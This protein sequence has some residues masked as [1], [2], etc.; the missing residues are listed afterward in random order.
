[1][2]EERRFQI[3][4]TADHDLAIDEIWPDGDAP[5]NPT[6]DDV[7]RR[8]QECGGAR[9]LWR[10]W[11]FDTDPEVDVCEVAPLSPQQLAAIKAL[12]EARGKR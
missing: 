10:D 2:S 11:G 5:E 8:I 3:T 9:G 7:K 4:I 1:M 6:V 12:A